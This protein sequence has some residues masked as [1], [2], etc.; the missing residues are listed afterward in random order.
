MSASP[1]AVRAPR[2]SSRAA[3][4]LGVGGAGAQGQD[5]GGHAEG[6]GQGRHHGQ[7]DRPAAALRGA[8]AVRCTHAG[9]LSG[10]G[11]RRGD[12]RRVGR[13][14]PAGVV[15][16]LARRGS[17]VVAQ[18][19]S[20]VP[21]GCAAGA[22]RCSLQC[23]CPAARRRRPGLVAAHTSGRQW[24]VM[25]RGGLAGAW[26]AGGAGDLAEAATAADPDD[27]AGTPEGRPSRGAVQNSDQCRSRVVA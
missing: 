9:C 3:D 18:R 4:E 16:A 22:G 17:D 12:A 15:R 6:D 5:D 25:R 1:M 11:L 24:Y 20:V 23:R 19:H 26:G 10:A 7:D 14:P 2:R 13:R 8:G 21:L 27:V